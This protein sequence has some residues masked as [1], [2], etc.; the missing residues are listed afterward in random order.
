M[1]TVAVVG[2]TGFI[3]RLIVSQLLEQGFSVRVLTRNLSNMEGVGAFRFKGDFS[4]ASY[5]WAAFVEGVGVVINAAAEL[6]DPSKMLVVNHQ[7]PSRLLDASKRAG[8]SRWIQFS[9]VGAYGALNQGVVTEHSTEC[10]IGMY[11]TTKTMFDDYLR[12]SIQGSGMKYTILRPSIVYGVGMRNQSLH[13]MM[14]ILKMGFFSFIGKPGS[15]AN[16]VHVDD[17]VRALILA[18]NSPNAEDET[19]IV[20]DYGTIEDMASSIAMGLNVRPPKFRIPL[21]FARYLAFSFGWV[22]K[23]PLSLGRVNAL[24]NRSQYSTKKIENDLG[25]SVT[26]PLSQGMKDLAEKVMF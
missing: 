24:T 20:S 11:E 19:Y 14:R 8:V 5:D 1:T 21:K 23:W 7:G 13:Q 6:T 9:S 17:L 2:G 25:W 3:G 26:V 18:L 12:S 15:S 10:P 22:P 16:Y 4:D